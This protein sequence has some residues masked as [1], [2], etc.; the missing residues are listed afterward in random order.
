[1]PEPN[2]NST[3]AMSMGARR[4]TLDDIWAAVVA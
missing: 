1:M 4:W 3:M 2:P